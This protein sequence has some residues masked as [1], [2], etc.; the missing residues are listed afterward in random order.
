MSFAVAVGG[1][2]GNVGQEM[3]RI[4]EQRDFPVDSLV[5]LA[6]PASFV[7]ELSRSPGSPGCAV[8]D[9]SRCSAKIWRQPLRGGAASARAAAVLCS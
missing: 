7:G 1:A 6:S 8:S 9:E 2:T 3:L 5:P 4:L